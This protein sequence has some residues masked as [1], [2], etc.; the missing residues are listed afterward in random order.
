M[1]TGDSYP[2]A[3]GYQPEPDD[4]KVMI[5]RVCEPNSRTLHEG[6]D[7]GQ[8]MQVWC[9]ERLCGRTLLSSGTR[10]KPLDR[11]DGH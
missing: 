7:G 5:E 11:R 2:C 8:L 9:G 4:S 3:P 10:L 1:H 6:V